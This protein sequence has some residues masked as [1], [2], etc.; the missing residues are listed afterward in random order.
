MPICI[1]Y[2]LTPDHR[3][4]FSKLNTKVIAIG[5]FMLL[6][7]VYMGPL[8]GW[9]EYTCYR[10]EIPTELSSVFKSSRIYS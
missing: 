1:D 9:G 2:R 7:T 8:Y 3:S 6:V 10:G 5:T 4:L